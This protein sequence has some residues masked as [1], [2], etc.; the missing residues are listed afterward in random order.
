MEDKVGAV[1]EGVHRNRH[2]VR[3]KMYDAVMFSLINN[4]VN[5]GV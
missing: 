3:D 2:V 5:D 4:S 1:R